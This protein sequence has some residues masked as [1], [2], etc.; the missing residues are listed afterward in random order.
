MKNRTSQPIRTLLHSF[1]VVAALAT[2]GTL[3]S[4][5]CEPVI[6]PPPDGRI[7]SFVIRNSLSGDYYTYEGNKLKTERIPFANAGIAFDYI[8][9][10]YSYL[11]D[12]VTEETS[13]ASTYPPANVTYQTV[14]YTYDLNPA[15]YIIKTKQ[16]ELCDYD[17]QGHRT[18]KG[19]DIYFWDAAGNMTQST[20]NGV[21]T[22][23]TYTNKKDLRIDGKDWLHG[24]R[25]TYLPDTKTINGETQEYDYLIDGQGRVLEENIRNGHRLIY[26]YF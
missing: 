26:T 11:P 6:P 17:A 1:L 21:T 18:K 3:P 19:N 7:A 25:S 10:S 24:K 23:Y 14:S 4:C 15:G 9:I 8:K 16:G 5:K 22:T 12:K 2:I 20:V 13:T